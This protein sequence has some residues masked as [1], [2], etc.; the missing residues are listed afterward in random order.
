MLIFFDNLAYP[1]LGGRPVVRRVV[2]WMLY[3]VFSDSFN[4]ALDPLGKLV[5]YRPG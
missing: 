4:R 5:F 1:G 3:V 2:V